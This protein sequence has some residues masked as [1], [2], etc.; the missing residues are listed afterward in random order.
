MEIK[1]IGAR[2]TQRIASPFRPKSTSTNPFENNSF[3]GRTF[4][5]SV[6]PF[7]DVFQNTAKKNEVSKLKMM[8]ASVVSAVSNFKQRL[9]Q[10]IIDFAHNVKARVNNTVSAIKSLPQRIVAAKNDLSLK[11]SEKLNLYKP[12]EHK[13]AEDSGVK[14]L[15][16][17]EINTKARIV[18]LKHTWL[19]ENK[20]IAK[21]V[22]EAA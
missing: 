16:L 11:I 22:K 8:S 12:A 19:E 20:N 18:D 17:K 9:T 5:K 1:A 4:N 10:P 3:S 2:I 21:S 15:S 14:L 6:L 13:V 7:A